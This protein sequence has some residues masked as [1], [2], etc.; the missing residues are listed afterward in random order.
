MHKFIVNNR[1]RSDP[2]QLL[3]T[4]NGPTSTIKQINNNMNAILKLKMALPSPH[5]TTTSTTT[6]TVA[7]LIDVG[8]GTTTDTNNNINKNKSHHGDRINSSS[9][10]DCTHSSQSSRGSSNRDAKIT[11]DGKA[12]VPS[13]PN[14]IRMSGYLKKKRNVSI[15]SLAERNFLSGSCHQLLLFPRLSQLNSPQEA[16]K[17]Q[18][19]RQ[20]V[21]KKLLNL[22]LSL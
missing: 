18:T 7:H 4:N 20:L 11:E 16:R 14:T 19:E 5:P 10:S 2:P 12:E 13:S 6:S 1:I 3:L 22:I 21:I 15:F 17:V 9:S 8:G